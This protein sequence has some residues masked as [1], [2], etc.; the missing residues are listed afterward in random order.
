MK[1]NFKL[2]LTTLAM[3]TLGLSSC[4]QSG[5]SDDMRHNNKMVLSVELDRTSEEC[6]IGDTFTL[7]PTIRFRDD[8]VV[9]VTKEWKSSK[10]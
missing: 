6:A 5:D 8:Q 4:N 3:L 1:K 7:I 9:E 2:L 10:R